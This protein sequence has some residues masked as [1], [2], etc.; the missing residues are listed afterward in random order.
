[1]IRHWSEPPSDAL[2]RNRESLVAKLWL[3]PKS[4]DPPVKKKCFWTFCLAEFYQRYLF[5][6]CV[7]QVRPS[8]DAKMGSLSDSQFQ[9]RTFAAT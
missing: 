2:L 6:R 1:V 5:L 4:S 7:W 9:S 3:R 8:A